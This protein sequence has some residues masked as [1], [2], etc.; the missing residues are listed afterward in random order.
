MPR[1]GDPGGHRVT[2]RS[3]VGG[4]LIVMLQRP[5]PSPSPPQ[6]HCRHAQMVRVAGETPE[7]FNNAVDSDCVPLRGGPEAPQADLGALTQERCRVGN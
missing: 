2:G 4:H 7:V 5:V 1:R 6:G 3:G